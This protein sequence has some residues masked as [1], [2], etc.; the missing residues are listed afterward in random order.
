MTATLELNTLSLLKMADKKEI[1]SSF[2]P[3]EL[4]IV[5]NAYSKK[6][7]GFISNS[8]I[9]SGS[10]VAPFSNCLLLF[11]TLDK[12]NKPELQNTYTREV[13]DEDI[14]FDEDFDIDWEV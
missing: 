7:I 11:V 10:G 3:N 5:G 12:E 6:D 8:K 1:K 14:E 9:Y 2:F 4:F 13:I